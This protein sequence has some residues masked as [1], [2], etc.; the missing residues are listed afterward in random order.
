M[1]DIMSQLENVG[2][3]RVEK[4]ESE[5]ITELDVDEIFRM[6]DVDKS[7]AISRSVSWQLSSD[8]HFT[9]LQSRKQ[10]WPSNCC[11]RDL[12]LKT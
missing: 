12:G 4:K 3:V 8:L 1:Q 5:E 11:P 7:G 9:L 10:D 2:W 6:I